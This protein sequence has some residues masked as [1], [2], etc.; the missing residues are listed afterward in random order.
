[1]SELKIKVDPEIELAL[2]RN[3]TNSIINMAEGG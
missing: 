3:I 1:M 2:I